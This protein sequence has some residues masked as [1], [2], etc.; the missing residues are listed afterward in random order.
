ML[1]P[2]RTKYRKAFKGRINGYATR[3]AVLNYGAFGLKALEPERIIGKQIEAARVALT[4]YMKRTGKVW[5][6]IFPNIPVSKKPTEVRMG[7]GKGAPEYWVACIKPGTILFEAAGVSLDL[8][9]EALSLAA[10]KLPIS[11]RF[12]VKRD[13]RV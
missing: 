2:V 1:Q 4:R 12:V 7:K 5:T 3:A 6:R 10:Q 9:K 8:A 11:S 13:Y